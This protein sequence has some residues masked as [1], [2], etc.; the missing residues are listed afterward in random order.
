MSD[1]PKRNESIT[2]GID[3]AGWPYVRTKLTY[4]QRA[5]FGWCPVCQAKPDQWCDPTRGIILGWTVDGRLPPSG[6]HLGRLQRAPFYR[7]LKYE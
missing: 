3:P 2:E 6:V 5:T 7:I 1:E 4:E